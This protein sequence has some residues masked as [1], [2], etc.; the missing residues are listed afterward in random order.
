MTSTPV[1]PYRELVEKYEALLEVQRSTTYTRQ[2]PAPQMTL[3]DELMNS[4][5]FSSFNTKYTSDDDSHKVAKIGTGARRKTP[6]DFSEVETSSSGFSDETSHKYTQTDERPG[7]FLCTIADGEDCKFTIYDDASP[8]DSRFRDRPKYRDLFREIFSV[9]KKAAE[10][11]DEGEQLPLLDDQQP[12]LVQVKVPPVT[13]A[14]EEQPYDFDSMSVISSVISENSIAVSECVTKTERRKAKQH[15]KQIKDENQPPISVH[16]TKDGK[17]V[18]PYNRQPLEYLTLT[19]S[20]KK[21][22]RRSRQCSKDKYGRDSSVATSMN[23]S[24]SNS[25]S[26]LSERPDSPTTPTPS[27]NNKK[28]RK[29][30]QKMLETFSSTSTSAWNEWNGSSL[31]VYNRNAD[32]PGPSYNVQMDNTSEIEFRPSTASQNLN[33]WKKLELSYAEVLRKGGSRQKRWKN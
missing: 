3:H 11:K 13:P 19:N 23:N 1:N 6:V 7:A 9:L 20:H 10:N 21:R 24:N 29:H 14:A 27:R 26:N 16:M 25:V 17:L 15:K 18:T 2:R 22:A 32:L 30:R 12:A 28:G 8:I 5:D 31:T 4:G 33:K